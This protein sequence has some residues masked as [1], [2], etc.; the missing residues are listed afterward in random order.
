[1]TV[2]PNPS[3]GDNINLLLNGFGDEDILVVIRDIQ[4][5]VFYSREH[6]VSDK[7]QLIAIH[8]DD[9]LSAGTYLV[10]AS[11]E[12]TIVSRKIIVR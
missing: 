6:T 10:I 8:L 3:G 11:S 1:M 12:E 4:G 2:Y 7:D 5:R 9:R